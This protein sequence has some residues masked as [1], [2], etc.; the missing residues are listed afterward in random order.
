MNISVTPR[1]SGYTQRRQQQ[2][3]RH[4]WPDDPGTRFP[5]GSAK[6]ERIAPAAYT[7]W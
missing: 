3:I 1:V 4:Q 2:M 6:A 7:T 5:H